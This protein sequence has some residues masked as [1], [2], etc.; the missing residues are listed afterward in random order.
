[1]NTMSMMNMISDNQDQ[2]LEERHEVLF[3]SSSTSPP[4]IYSSSLEVI[5][6]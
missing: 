6:L 2:Y 4:N 5:A 1:M 3:D